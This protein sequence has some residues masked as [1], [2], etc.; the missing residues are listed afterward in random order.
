[1]I[2]TLVG[3]GDCF[4]FGV[5]VGSGVDVEVL[6]G[7][8]MGS[9]VFDFV[10]VGVEALVGMSVRTNLVAFAWQLEIN[11][12]LPSNPRIRKKPLHPSLSAISLFFQIE[13]DSI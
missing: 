8:I 12:E 1:V 4:G 2:G 6:V 5:G 7:E 10:I 3:V 9:G 11:K 13:L